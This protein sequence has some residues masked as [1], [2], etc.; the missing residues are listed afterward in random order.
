MSRKQ[1]NHLTIASRYGRKVIK[2][3]ESS[4]ARAMPVRRLAVR[5]TKRNST[6]AWIVL[7]RSVRFLKSL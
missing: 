1:L 6:P 5:G 3:R 7:S 2:Y 4:R